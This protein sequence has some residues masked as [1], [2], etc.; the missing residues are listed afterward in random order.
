[1]PYDA[2]GRALQVRHATSANVE[3]DRAFYG[4]DSLCDPLV[5]MASPAAPLHAPL[6]F[7]RSEY[8]Q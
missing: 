4:Y 3:V 6:E 8:C 7:V 5:W 2:N 1:V